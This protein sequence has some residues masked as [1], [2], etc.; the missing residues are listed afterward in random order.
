MNTVGGFPSFI[1]SG[2]RPSFLK[3]ELFSENTDFATARV[4]LREVL[5]HLGNYGLKRVWAPH[6]VCP[7][8][9]AELKKHETI[10]EIK[11]YNYS[12]E[13][14][15]I[16]PTNLTSEDAVYVYPPFGLDFV[17]DLGPGNPIKIFDGSHSLSLIK[18]RGDYEITSLRKFL[19]VNSGA[20]IRSLDDQISEKPTRR[21]GSLNSFYL[22]LKYPGLE[23]FREMSLK[24]YRENERKLGANSKTLLGT[25]KFADFTIRRFRLKPMVRKRRANLRILDS[26]L[27]E[28]NQLSDIFKS[29]WNS[30]HVP[31]SYPFVT[32]NSKIVRE[33]LAE[34]GVFT[35]ILWDG[36]DEKHLTPLEIILANNVIHLPLNGRYDKRQL[37]KLS[38]ILS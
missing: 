5:T 12:S 33:R 26:I 21:H 24:M 4:A 19:P 15:A 1:D 9:T 6:F 3:G 29:V 13:C 23:V 16:L 2:F 22:A 28:K 32:E 7:E 20:L 27:G 37:S 36:L 25:S 31:Y 11:Y 18:P 14:K 10:F 38:D 8:I 17:M 35:P 34:A 30:D